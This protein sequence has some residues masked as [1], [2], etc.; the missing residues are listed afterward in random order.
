MGKYAEKACELFLNDANCAQAVFA[1]FADK[2]GL[3]EAFAMKLA[4]SFGGGMGRLREVCGAV[5]GMFMVAG[6]LFG[7]DYN[8]NEKKKAHYALIQEM[9]KKF[10][11]AHGT[12]ICR[13]LLKLSVKTDTPT[14]TKRDASFYASRP[15]VRFVETAALILE[16]YVK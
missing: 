9:A 4:S 2:M 5:S 1:A 15:C 16:E 3:E 7:Y 13:D 10:T 12:I 14:P 6:A 8:D 11:D